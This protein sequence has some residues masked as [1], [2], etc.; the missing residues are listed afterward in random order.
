[1]KKNK[2]QRILNKLTPIDAGVSDTFKL[3]DEEISKLS[4]RLK[5]TITTKTLED[6]NKEFKNLQNL[7]TP[8]VS[9]VD[10]L[11][12]KALDSEK[13]LQKQIEDRITT[14]QNQLS[15]VS[16][17]ADQND[18]ELNAEIE[19]LKVN[20]KSLSSKEDFNQ[21][22]E[23][24]LNK[25]KEFNTSIDELSSRIKEPDFTSVETDIES[26]NER[27]DKFRNEL[28]NRINSIGGGSQNQKITVEGTVMSTKY[29]DFNLKAGSNITLSKSD[30]NTNRRVDITITA[31][32]GGG[33]HTIQ[34]E[35]T[36]LTQRT[37][38]N[39]VGAGVTVTDDSG[40]DATVITIP[41]GSGDWVS[42]LVGAEISIT[43]TA[44]ATISRQHVIS[45]TSADYTVTLPASS[46]NTGKFIGLRIDPSA[47]K[48]FTIDGN[49][50]ET[51][52]GSLTR[53]M[54]AGES[55]LLYCDGSNWFKV[56]GKSIP[57][58]CVAN[59]SNSDKTGIASGVRTVVEMDTK[60][61]GMDAM[62]DSG[63]GR[64]KAVRP[65]TY[66]VTAFAYLSSLANFGVVGPGLNGTTT[67]RG[68][69]FSAQYVGIFVGDVT[70]IMSGISVSDYFTVVVL[71]DGVSNTVYGA[72][73][74]A[75]TAVTEIITW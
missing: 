50:S 31:S 63:N 33:G 44:T 34:D 56:A 16:R 59:R 29:A 8:L 46:G 25:Q 11:K 4:E 42:T 12:E 73:E 20:L 71:G 28:T 61:S 70:V 35:G 75:I 38:L 32:G 52:D 36:P 24:L 74:P 47:T 41:G 10:N 21:L 65:G 30:D 14:L 49:S 40:N 9:A 69:T 72:T 6:V 7:I 27:L 13:S 57:M 2:L 62:W 53:I 67:P 60:V 19:T 3:V 39:F 58:A 37:N 64:I 68:Y 26:L 18:S 17:E 55:A 15:S 45:G 54:W 5:E 1:M 66:A 43:T 48:L 23:Y 22:R 51:I